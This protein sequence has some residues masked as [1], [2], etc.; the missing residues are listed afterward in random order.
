MPPLRDRGSDA[1]ILADYCLE[2][3][4]STRHGRTMS[5]SKKSEQII[6]TYSWPGNIRELTNRV[7]RAALLCESHQITPQDLGFSSEEACCHKVMTLANA[8]EEA[9]K[10]VIVKSLAYTDHNIT[11]ASK[12]LDISRL[13]LYRLISKYALDSKHL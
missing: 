13:S 8:R 5:F 2:K 7:K 4:R 6:K 11:A 3:W 10:T 1:K 9:D 12:L